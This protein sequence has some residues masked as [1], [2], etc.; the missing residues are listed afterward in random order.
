MFTAIDKI[1]Q[2]SCHHCK[3]QYYPQ[4]SAFSGGWDSLLCEPVPVPGHGAIVQEIGRHRVLCKEGFHSLQNPLGPFGKAVPVA[5][6]HLRIALRP[7]GCDV[8]LVVL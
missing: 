7:H 3:A 2:H 8:V 5:V 1:L 4:A 6:A